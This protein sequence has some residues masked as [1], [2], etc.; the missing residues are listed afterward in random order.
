[1]ANEFELQAEVRNDL[2]KGASRRLRR[3]AG[4]VPLLF[5]A[6]AKNQFQFLL[7]KMCCTNLV[8]TK[9]FSLTSLI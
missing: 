1:M 3:N 2:G 6:R 5:M 9:H 8:R 4:M 7:H